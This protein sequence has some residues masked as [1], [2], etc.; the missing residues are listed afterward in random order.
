MCGT[1]LRAMG[2][3]L[4]VVRGGRTVRDGP[5]VHIRLVVQSI[6]TSTVIDS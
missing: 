1:Y 5:T 2:P 3:A 6:G 4:G